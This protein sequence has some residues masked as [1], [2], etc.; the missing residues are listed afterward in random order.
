MALASIALVAGLGL[1]A[2]S[3]VAAV[4]MLAVGVLGAVTSSKGLVTPPTK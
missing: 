4:V 3:V 1:G 2:C